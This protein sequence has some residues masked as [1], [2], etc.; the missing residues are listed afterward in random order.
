MSGNAAI[1]VS[2]SSSATSLFSVSVSILPIMF[3]GGWRVVGPPATCHPLPANIQIHRLPLRVM[4][5]HLHSELASQTAAFDAA[6]RRLEM[7][8]AAGI[9]RQISGLHGARDAKCA[10]DVA[11]PDRAGQ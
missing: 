1:T 6:E 10:A 4:I 11:S 2:I 5:E 7:H 3:N 9:D 8:T